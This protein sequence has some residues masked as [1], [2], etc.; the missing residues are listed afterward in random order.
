MYSQG[1]M[2]HSRVC[3]HRVCVPIC[4]LIFVNGDFLAARAILRHCSK[5][6]SSRR[7]VSGSPVLHAA[8]VIATGVTP[9][10][11]NMHIFTATVSL[12]QGKLVQTSNVTDIL[13]LSTVTLLQLERRYGTA[14]RRDGTSQLHKFDAP[15]AAFAARPAPKR[16]LSAAAVRA[17]FGNG[18]G[19]LDLR[20]KVG[21][22][23]RLREPQG[24]QLS[25]V[26]VSWQKLYTQFAIWYDLSSYGAT[27]R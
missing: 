21:G 15:A 10:H 20:K 22:G 6:T 13:S 27:C 2:T 23:V 8:F 25:K 1:G 16:A 18:N 12:W 19:G 5:M 7:C 3:V 17:P 11:V 14:A 4:H 26:R 24:P 9:Q